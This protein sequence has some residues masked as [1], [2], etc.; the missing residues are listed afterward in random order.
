[1]S[2]LS[3]VRLTG[4]LFVLRNVRDERLVPRLPREVREETGRPQEEGQQRHYRHGDN[5]RQRVAGLFCASVTQ[6][7]YLHSHLHVI[8]RAI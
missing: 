5:Q 7:I 3:G 2:F 8:I 6:E 4:S 1:M